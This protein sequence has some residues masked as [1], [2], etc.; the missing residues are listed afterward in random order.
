MVLEIHM[1]IWQTGKEHKERTK[2]KCSESSQ[3]L[4]MEEGKNNYM[5]NQV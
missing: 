5:N 1:S 4:S 2:C 3:E